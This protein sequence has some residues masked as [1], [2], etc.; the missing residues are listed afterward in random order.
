MCFCCCWFFNFI[1]QSNLFIQT[2]AQHPNMASF[3]P[4]KTTNKVF[5]SNR[6]AIWVTIYC[7]TMTYLSI[8]EN[9]EHF[10]FVCWTV[11]LKRFWSTTHSPFPSSWLSFVRKSASPIT[12]NMVWCAKSL[13][14]KT[15]ICRTTKPER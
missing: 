14:S 15:K 13:N 2:H 9:Y 7:V 12:K 1:T 8:D 3:Y 5:G 10:A 6:D 4:T 11:P